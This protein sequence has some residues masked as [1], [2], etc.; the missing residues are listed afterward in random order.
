[1]SRYVR[2]GQADPYNPPDYYQSM[3]TDP[4]QVPVQMYPGGG[5][6]YGYPGGATFGPYP[7]F[8]LGSRILEPRDAMRLAKER[9]V[10]M[11]RRADVTERP[12]HKY[13]NPE[14]RV[15]GAAGAALQAEAARRKTAPQKDVVGAM[16]K[17]ILTTVLLGA[18]LSA[19][20]R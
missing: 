18:V 1:M 3:I 17:K 11:E 2:F 20:L 19:L 13:I 7:G 14:G 12:E 15:T 4:T 9:Q 8:Y 6:P 16:Q 10:A 5:Y